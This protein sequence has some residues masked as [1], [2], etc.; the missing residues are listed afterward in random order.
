[1]IKE[2]DG[3]EN[4]IISDMRAKVRINIGSERRIKMRE[5]LIDENEGVI[6]EGMNVRRHIVKRSN[7]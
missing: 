6:S 4:G 2:E 1:M 3:M 5:E 7:F